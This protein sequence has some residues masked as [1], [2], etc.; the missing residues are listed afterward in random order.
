MIDF[1]R[2]TDAVKLDQ[3]LD[4]V[5]QQI[6]ILLGT[7]PH[8]VLGD[9]VYGSD[10]EKFIWDLT[11]TNGEIER[12]VSRLLE[13]WVDFLSFD[14]SVKVDILKGT[15]SDIILVTIGL[16]SDGYSYEKTYNIEK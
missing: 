6:D 15:D 10:C 14:H 2:S 3:D 12:Y 7:D 1:C 9:P 11:Y 5:L 16:I 4:L 13:Y 8:E